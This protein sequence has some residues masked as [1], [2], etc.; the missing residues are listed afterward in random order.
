M[1]SKKI[2]EKFQICNKC[3]EINCLYN[4]K[5]RCYCYNEQKKLSKQGECLNYI[6]KATPNINYIREFLDTEYMNIP[7]YLIGGRNDRSNKN[8]LVHIE[9]FYPTRCLVSFEV[10]NHEFKS[11]LFNLDLINCELRRRKDEW[12]EE[13][14]KINASHN[15]SYIELI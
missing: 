1:K 9:R 10:N 15:L 2:N 8:Y 5:E 7:G 13:T 3:K 12:E 14:R 4:Y 11:N 6:N